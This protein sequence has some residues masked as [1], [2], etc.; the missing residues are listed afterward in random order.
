M[1]RTLLRSTND[2]WIAGVFGGMSRTFDWNSTHVRI[3]VIVLGM[4]MAGVP[5]V[6]AYIVMWVAMPEDAE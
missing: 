6:L 2:R 3:W 4:L 5:L 1:Q